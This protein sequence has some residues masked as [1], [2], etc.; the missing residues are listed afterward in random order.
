MH[1]TNYSINKSAQEN[2]TADQPVQK[3]TLT[4]FWA[5]LTRQGY[6]AESLKSDI[7]HLAIKAVIACESYIRE[8]QNVH[9]KYP[10]VRYGCLFALE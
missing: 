6:D 1:L 9:S 4:E 8:H 10:F 5:Y 2:G 3:W 7:Q